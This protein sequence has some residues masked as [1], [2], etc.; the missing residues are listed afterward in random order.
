[1]GSRA[2]PA[3][4]GAFLIGAAALAVLAVV[5]L[6]SGR[7]FQKKHEYLLYFRGNVN[8][9]RVGAPVKFKGVEIGSVTRILLNVN[10]S[11]GAIQP[12]SRGFGIPVIVELEQGRLVS[13]GA[14]QINLDDPAVLKEMIRMGL[15]GQLAMESFVTGVLYI[16]LDMHPEAPSTLVLPAG[17]PYPEIPTIPTPFE[18][19]QSAA[20]ML[21]GQ[22]EA[23]DFK[24]LAA[25]I[26]DT[27]AAIDQFATSS[28]L[29]TAIKNL[30][31]TEESLRQAAVGIRQASMKMDRELGP[32]AGSLHASSRS[33]DA[34]LTQARSTLSTIQNSLGEDSPLLYQTGRTMEDLDSAARSVRQLS[35]FLQRNPGAAVRG[36]S[37]SGARQ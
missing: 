34:T 8:G 26:R 21:I 33:A 25:E 7:L 18:Q 4:I 30:A 3:T 5:V 20:S 17:A 11:Q 6:G 2:N 32:L 14:T 10:L 37:F 28:E 16:D 22:L 29:K 23:V 24:K 19:A 9:L 35:D 15:R 12:I 1:M 31:A 13:H 36:R 27:L